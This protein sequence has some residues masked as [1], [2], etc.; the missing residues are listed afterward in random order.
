MLLERAEFV[1]DSLPRRSLL[2][3]C[4]SNVTT[5]VVLRLVL[6]PLSPSPL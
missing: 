1:I 3:L 4:Y 2:Q 6:A 5:D